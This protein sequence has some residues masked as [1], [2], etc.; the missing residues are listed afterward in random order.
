MGKK[1]GE[2]GEIRRGIV[3]FGGVCPACTA[4]MQGAG[5]GP[6]TAKVV[7]YSK[8]YADGWE[9]TFGSVAEV[10]KAAE[11]LTRS[12]VLQEARYTVRGKA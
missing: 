5:T 10:D 3:V 2:D 9:T 11:E 6:G 8:A 7:G 12:A 1:K 4:E